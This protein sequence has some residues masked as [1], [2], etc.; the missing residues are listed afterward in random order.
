MSLGR[1]VWRARKGESLGFLSSPNPVSA[2]RQL[3]IAHTRDT[4]CALR[5]VCSLPWP[6]CCNK[7]GENDAICRLLPVNLTEPGEEGPDVRRVHCE[8]REEAT[9]AQWRDHS[10]SKGWLARFV[11]RFLFQRLVCHARSS[12]SPAYIPARCGSRGLCL[13]HWLP[14]SRSFAEDERPE[15]S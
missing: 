1:V 5:G 3:R 8:S 15:A 10:R 9:A 6:S 13:S 4:P 7:A 14:P 11:L 12:P 2:K